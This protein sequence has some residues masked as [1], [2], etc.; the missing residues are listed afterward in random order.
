MQKN[1]SALDNLFPPCPLMEFLAKGTSVLATTPKLRL[2]NTRKNL[3]GA[4][5]ILLDNYLVGIPSK[6]II[7]PQ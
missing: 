2:Q 3:F 1:Q 7:Y 6:I 4:R 5:P